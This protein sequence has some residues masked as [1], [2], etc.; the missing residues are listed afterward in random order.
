MTKLALPIA[1]TAL[2]GCDRNEGGSD[3]VELRWKDEARTLVYEYGAEHTARG[4]STQETLTIEL[5]GGGEAR[6]QTGSAAPVSGTLSPDGRVTTRAPADEARPMLPVYLDLFQ[7]GPGAGMALQ[8]GKSYTVR[9][10]RDEDVPQ[11]QLTIQS[12]V[13]ATLVKVEGGLATFDFETTYRAIDNAALAAFTEDVKSNFQG[14]DAYVLALIEAAKESRL[15]GFGTVSFDVAHGQLRNATFTGAGL[16]LKNMTRDELAAHA[17][18]YVYT[19]TL[20]E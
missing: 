20:R 4:L 13:E 15:A 14:D 2:V 3:A 5:L 19:L 16:P 17:D 18:A 9:I 6:F 10:P 8:P 11:D 7:V 12:E 1:L